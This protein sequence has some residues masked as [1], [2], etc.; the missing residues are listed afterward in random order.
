MMQTP[1]GEVTVLTTPK[2]IVATLS[3]LQQAMR[4]ANVKPIRVS[5]VLK[6][7]C[8]VNAVDAITHR[9]VRLLRPL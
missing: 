7:A 8:S 1:Q 4:N 3:R 2:L 5:D 6:H 9:A